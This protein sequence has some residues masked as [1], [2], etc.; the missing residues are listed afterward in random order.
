M[1]Q[2]PNNPEH[3][4]LISP[5]L[6]QRADVNMLHSSSHSTRLRSVM[7]AG[8]QTRISVKISAAL[9]WCEHV[10]SGSDKNSHSRDL[11]NPVRC[12][13]GHKNIRKLSWQQSFNHS[14]MKRILYGS[15]LYH[16]LVIQVHFL[17]KLDGF[18][19]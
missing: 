6:L 5:T 2:F 17:L 12:K 19:S 13:T 3:L 16:R 7:L 1:L 4:I 9:R 11:F 14:W 8:V 15:Y 18:S 10:A